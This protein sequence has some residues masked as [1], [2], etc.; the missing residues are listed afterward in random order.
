MTA[1]GNATAQSDNLEADSMAHYGSDRNSSGKRDGGV[2]SRK[3]EPDSAR[4]W[5][6]IGLN[7]DGDKRKIPCFY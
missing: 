6:M 2:E 7:R 1:V 5:R 3:Q 4:E